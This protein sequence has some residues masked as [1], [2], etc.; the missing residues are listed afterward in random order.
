MTKWTH[1]S[2]NS[3]FFSIMEER[4]RRLRHTRTPNLLPNTLLYQR[5]LVSRSTYDWKE[6]T[7]LFHVLSNLRNIILCLQPVGDQPAPRRLFERLCPHQ[8]PGPDHGVPCDFR[9]GLR[10]RLIAGAGHAVYKYDWQMSDR[11]HVVYNF[12]LWSV[13]R[14]ER[15][16][17]S[18]LPSKYESN[19][20]K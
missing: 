3:V 6:A 12:F 1:L 4:R 9:N 14:N 20:W 13:N 7:K 15:S 5:T 8:L 16:I 10:H 11:W 17:W 19:I 18:I 2:I